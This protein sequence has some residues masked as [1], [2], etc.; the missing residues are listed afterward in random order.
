[1]S[2]T[3][4][5]KKQT[6]VPET[7]TDFD[8][9]VEGMRRFLDTTFGSFARWPVVGQDGAWTPPVDV[10]E[11]DGAY[12][13]E[14][15]LP[16]VDRDD[17]T[18]ELVGNELTIRGEVKETPHTGVVRR[19]TRRSG[20]FEYWITLPDSVDADH[21]DA[22]LKDGVLKVTVPK[23]QQAQRRTIELKA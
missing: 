8:G 21:V 5:E 3:L 13:L 11:T 14:A 17:V 7:W 12:V 20:K 19:R 15:D 6:T 2:Q 9:M 18:V 23:A 22:S 1:M 4:P 10:E 16:G